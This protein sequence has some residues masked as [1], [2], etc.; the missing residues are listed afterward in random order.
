MQMI[1]TEV[2]VVTT[3]VESEIEY[4]PVRNANNKRERCSPVQAFRDPSPLLLPKDDATTI[5]I[6]DGTKK[7]RY[8]TEYWVQRNVITIMVSSHVS[9]DYVNIFCHKRGTEQPKLVERLVFSEN[10]NRVQSKLPF[11]SAFKKKL[12][13]TS[14][15][16][17]TQKQIWL[18]AEFCT[19]GQ[20]TRTCAT[21][22]FYVCSRPA[23]EEKSVKPASSFTVVET[24]RM[25]RVSFLPIT[26]PSAQET[27]PAS[28]SR[29]P[30]P[31]KF[32]D[33]P[34]QPQPI[35]SEMCP[36]YG[37]HSGGSAITIRIQNHNL[38]SSREVTVWFGLLPAS[39]VEILD[40]QTLVALTPPRFMPGTVQVAVIIDKKEIAETRQFIYTDKTEPSPRVMSDI[41]C[42]NY[43]NCSPKECSCEP[44]SKRIRLN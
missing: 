20:I 2:S 38:L 18:T 30:S 40:E 41:A 33:W 39:K 4:S 44:L 3:V 34:P 19:D 6:I 28:P 12:P 35:I 24:G 37:P 13:M 22:P 23:K 15:R 21:E 26:Q 1:A 5:K 9:F 36:A 29:Q 16:P 7:I 42:H 11:E 8:N 10:Q 14:G 17:E 31:V 32:I 25:K 27:Q 43:F